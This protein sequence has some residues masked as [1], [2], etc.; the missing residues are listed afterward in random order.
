LRKHLV[1]VHL[2][3]LA[4]LFSQGMGYPG[5]WHIWVNIPEF[6][7]RLYQG[8]ELYQTFN[9]AVGKLSTPSPVGEFRIVNKIVNPVWRPASKKP[10]PPGPDNP[11]GKYWLGLNAKGYGI[12]GNNAAWSVGNPVSKG[13]FRM[14]NEEVSLLFKVVP[15]GTE[16]KITYITVFGGVDAQKRAWL[17]LYPDIYRRFDREKTVEAVLGGLKWEFQPHRRA[18]R[19]LLQKGKNGKLEIPR[20][21]NRAGDGEEVDAFFWNDQLFIQD[22]SRRTTADA[23]ASLTEKEFSD[24]VGLQ[25]P[26]EL[27]GDDFRYCWNKE[28]NLLSVQRLKV[29]IDGAPVAQAGKR[30]DGRLYVDLQKILRARGFE[31]NWDRVATVASVAG[32][33]L[34]GKIID[35]FFWAEIGEVASIWPDFK[36]DW[37]EASWTLRVETGGTGKGFKNAF[38]LRNVPAEGGE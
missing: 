25:S 14:T 6:K 22:H 20:V 10:A 33:E 2:I 27:S 19:E 17:M 28:A 15:V 37:D 11:L 23:V 9:V 31:F 32:T 18:L 3:M 5:S 26:A 7:L 24:Y 38:S 34:A 30:L 4:A 29:F 21:V 12:H 16:V 13:C 1:I 35:D 8:T 36:Y